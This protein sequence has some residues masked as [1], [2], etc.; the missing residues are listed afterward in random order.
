MVEQ[1]GTSKPV[2]HMAQTNT[3]RRLSVSF[4]NFS[5]RS[6]FS[7]RCRCGTMSRPF[8]ARSST[9][10]WP[11]D[12]T[13]AMSVVSIRWMRAISASRAS[14]C[15]GPST[16][17]SRAISAFQCVCTLSYM[18]TAVALSM[19]TIIALPR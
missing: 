1:V 15:A 8:F 13:T 3:R 9:S 14:P 12:T 7:S 10:F 17:F 2:I 4:L 11:C 16:A 19:H 6:S 18:R 5:A